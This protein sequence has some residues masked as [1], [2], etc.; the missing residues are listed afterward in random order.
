MIEE[1]QKSEESEILEDVISRF[2]L[3]LDHEQKEFVLST[4]KDGHSFGQA[5]PGSGKTTCLIAMFVYLVKGLNV[6]RKEILMMSFNVTS[7]EVIR[8]RLAAKLG[9]SQKTYFENS[10]TYHSVGF[11]ACKRIKR[12]ELVQS[13]MEFVNAA[14]AKMRNRG[15]DVQFESKEAMRIISF[16]KNQGCYATD[17]DSP[18]PTIFISEKCV[19]QFD[20]YSRSALESLL[21]YYELSKGDLIDHDDQLLV[22][23]LAHSRGH[24]AF[25]FLKKIKYLFVDELQDAN[26][27]QIGMVKA[28][29]NISGCKV[30]AVG[31]AN[32]SVYGWRGANSSNMQMFAEEF[33]AKEYKITYNYRSTQAI[34]D[35]ASAVIK[36]KGPLFEDYKMQASSSSQKGGVYEIYSQSKFHELIALH[37][38]IKHLQSIYDLRRVFVIGR[39]NASLTGTAKYLFKN[40]ISVI[41]KSDEGDDCGVALLNTAAAVFDHANTDMSKALTAIRLI[42]DRRSALA[43]SRGFGLDDVDASSLGKGKVA[44]RLSK[45]L[46]SIKDIRER[47]RK[48][49]IWHENVRRFTDYVNECWQALSVLSGDY[50]KAAGINMKAEMQDVLDFLQSSAKMYSPKIA[51]GVVYDMF[52]ANLSSDRTN[53]LE[54]LT[55]HRAKGQENDVVIIIDGDNF[56]CVVV[57]EKDPGF[58]QEPNLLF[59][60][61]SRAR[62]LLFVMRSPKEYQGNHRQSRLYDKINFSKRIKFNGSAQEFFEEI[63]EIDLY[64]KEKCKEERV[65]GPSILSDGWPS[66]ISEYAREEDLSL[67]ASMISKKLASGSQDFHLHL[68]DPQKWRSVQGQEGSYKELLYNMI[69]AQDPCLQLRQIYA[70]MMKKSIQ[71]EE[72][73]HRLQSMWYRAASY[74]LAASMGPEWVPSAL[75]GR[76]NSRYVGAQVDFVVKDPPVEGRNG[77]QTVP[78]T[79]WSVIADISGHPK[80]RAK[81]LVKASRVVAF[82]EPGAQ[83]VYK[84][85]R[86]ECRPMFGPSPMLIWRSPNEYSKATTGNN[87]HVPPL[88]ELIA[89]KDLAALAVEKVSK[90]SKEGRP[91]EFPVCGHLW[92]HKESD[93]LW[94][95]HEDSLVLVKH[96]DHLYKEAYDFEGDKKRRAFWDTVMPENIPLNRDIDIEK[97]L[98]YNQSV[99]QKLT[100]EAYEYALSLVFGLPASSVTSE[101]SGRSMLFR[102]PSPDVSKGLAE[103]LNQYL[104]VALDRPCRI[105]SI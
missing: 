68:I 24:D 76:G 102:I 69:H 58:E 50:A 57:D 73:R 32:Q 96:E 101:A 3:K 84:M 10:R 59:V 89:Q 54:F 66:T 29:Q 6:P 55:A 85:V 56:P 12:H 47:V 28:I 38:L 63:N 27:P 67:F 8:E 26:E 105:N 87:G 100:P 61:A 7:A 19:E 45:F 44:E 1:L 49:V 9:G 88:Q 95:F 4:S 16:L 13:S 23:W 78:V 71:P 98:C 52:D 103:K 77:M 93:C 81:I 51:L 104:N 82:F 35:A 20:C 25:G 37:E 42:G 15:Q 72:K 34:V 30:I 99:I 60:A 48:D 97:H 40:G 14:M 21:Y 80:V 86:I 64:E 75:S 62:K 41:C 36:A 46:A 22:P 5:V 65:G 43:C 17:L 53:S 94:P 83:S 31:D 70:N 90:L 2:G 33:R 92:L 91:W 11:E 74:A 79:V 39:T 18:S